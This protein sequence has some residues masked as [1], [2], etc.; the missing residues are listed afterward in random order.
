MH[1]PLIGQN[2][3]VTHDDPVDQKLQETLDVNVDDGDVLSRRSLLV[4]PQTHLP[5]RKPL[6]VLNPLFG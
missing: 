5:T 3:E 4:I 2:L 1:D 6:L